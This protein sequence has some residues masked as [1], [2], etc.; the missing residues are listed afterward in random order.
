MYYY[1]IANV[2]TILKSP[3][4]RT[5][6]RH[7][8]LAPA[9]LSNPVYRSI[10]NTMSKSGIK[11]ILD[12]GAAEAVDIGLNVYLQIVEDLN[13]W[14]VILPDLLNRPR[15]QSRAKSLDFLAMLKAA[16]YTGHVMYVPQ[17]SNQDEILDEYDW[18]ATDGLALYHW[19][20][21]MGR[22]FLHWGTQ[23]VHRIQMFQEVHQNAAARNA[24][25]HILGATTHPTIYYSEQP[26][27]IG[28]DSSKPC[29]CALSRLTY[30][31][32]PPRG[33]RDT[34]RKCAPEQ[35]LVTNIQSFCYKYGAKCE[36]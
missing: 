9:I 11:F 18:A 24:S 4:A 17:G 7:L 12:N 6:P 31:C 21:G 16:K 35:L 1:L 5:Y 25:F 10:L 27:V 33:M 23:E 2:G 28:I 13:P 15:L 19:R 8:V 29:N 26:N 32:C 20:L 3:V 30:P 14:C 36:I 34:L 22:S